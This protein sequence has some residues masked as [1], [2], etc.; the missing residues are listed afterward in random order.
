MYNDSVITSYSI[1]YTKLYDIDV[2]VLDDFG[3][4][5]LP[6]QAAQDLYDLIAE[7]YERRSFIITSNRAFE[8]WAE[9]F[10]N[11]SYNFV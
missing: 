2:L 3:L 5:P 7:R 9:V 11:D 4:Q 8:E 6:T 10:G 1:H